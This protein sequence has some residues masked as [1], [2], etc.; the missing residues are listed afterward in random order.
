MKLKFKNGSVIE[1]LESGNKQGATRGARAEIVCMVDDKC[2][3]KD[4]LKSI[5]CKNKNDYIS[6]LQRFKLQ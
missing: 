1:S 6:G 2:K 5:K 4:K 3:C